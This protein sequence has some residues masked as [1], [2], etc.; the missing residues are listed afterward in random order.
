MTSSRTIIEVLRRS[1]QGTTQPFLCRADDGQQYYVKGK[2][3]GCGSLCS[4][5]IASSLARNF[6]LPVPPFVIAEVPAVLVEESARADIEQLGAGLVF[7]SQALDG[8]REITWAEASGCAPELKARLLLFDWWVRNEDR[9]LTE[10]RG[11]PN[12]LVTPG[13]LGP[14]IW[15]FDFNLAFDPSFSAENFWTYHVF[16]EMVP[17]W[18]PG[19]RETIIP[20]LQ[21]GL[22]RLT[23][24]YQ[25][26]P[27]EWLFLGG[28]DTTD[29]VLGEDEVRATLSRAFNQPDE[30]WRRG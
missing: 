16:A 14:Q 2:G 29:P 17:A 18:P 5:W 28:D 26:L 15:T 6:D 9:S 8:A 23:T 7:A 19:F 25:T 21:S 22:D 11:N 12:L 24:V 1:E 27:T 20:A 13:E 30:F 3:A 10:D 4:E